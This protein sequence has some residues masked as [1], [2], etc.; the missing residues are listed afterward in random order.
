MDIAI[1]GCGITGLTLAHGLIDKCRT[2]NV[3]DRG[4]AGGLGGGIPFPGHPSVTIEKFYHHL[5][6]DDVDFISLLEEFGLRQD[7]HFLK[8][9]TGLFAKGKCWPLEKPLDFL[10]FRPLGSLWERAK[11]GWNLRRF[12]RHANWQ[13]YD[14]ISCREY[15]SNH[16]SRIGYENLWR[17][18]LQAKYADL[19][20]STPAAILWGRIYPRARSR[21][22]GAET[23]G[24]LRG[25]FQ[26]LVDR[27]IARLKERGVSFHL[28]EE[29][30][31]VEPGP[32]P[33]IKTCRNQTSFDRVIWTGPL[34]RLAAA[35]PGLDQRLASKLTS[36]RYM[37]VA[38]LL[39]VLK[40]RLG[41]YYWLNNID[42]SISF[43]VL[44]EHTNLVSP[45]DYGGMHF[46]Y[47]G[48][49]LNANHHYMSL[50]RQGLL[51]VHWPSLCRLFPGLNR[52][53]LHDYFAIKA[54][55]AAPVF[56]VD[57]GSHMLSFS[58]DI[59]GVDIVG[60]AQV[61]PE[62]RN[63]SHCAKIARQ[64][65]RENWAAG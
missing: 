62:D 34:C 33:R 22:R 1:V 49:Y 57:Q 24:Y 36:F 11:M 16:G 54:R 15:F 41:E 7:L 8:S 59:P 20:D 19:F 61:Y 35:I 45:S 27:M 42:P 56:A 17:P 55:H 31:G 23:L 47:V 29:V 53:D 46:A 52:D 2:I 51:D 14:G 4:R 5:F 9:R 65:L 32:Q 13:A 21:Q 39:L 25:G 37:A 64:Y 43:G 26:R 63:M 6:R 50:S 48:N 60:M 10:R 30:Q 40:R 58:G 12:T 38:C 28:G 44:V 18:L 3:F